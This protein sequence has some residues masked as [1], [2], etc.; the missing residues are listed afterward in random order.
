MNNATLN[1][2]AVGDIILEGSLGEKAF[3][4]VAPVLRSG[5]V[6][7]GQGECPF[8]ARGEPFLEVQE[9]ANY[10][11]GCPPVHMRALA[12][13]G[14]N[15]ITPCSNH[16]YN[17]GAPGIED[18]IT[19]LK[20]LGIAYCG[21]GM[22]IDEA[23]RPAVIE[24]KGTKVGVL[25]YNCV[26]PKNSW[27]LPDRPGCAFV[28]V[29]THYEPVSTGPG[30]TPNIYSFPDPNSLKDMIK[31][32]QKLRPDCDVLVVSFHKGLLDGAHHRLAMYEQTISYAAIDAGADLVLGHHSHMLKGIEIYRGKA[33]FHNLGHF[34]PDVATP[35]DKLARLAKYIRNVSGI[36][37]Q[38]SGVPFPDSLVNDPIRRRTIIARCSI[39][40]GHISRVGYI[41]CLITDRQPRI[42]K[43]DEKGQEVFDHLDKIT[44]EAGLDTRYEWEGDEVIIYG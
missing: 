19:G 5:D 30:S 29:I 31:D 4:F 44:R 17:L 18:T 22:N 35:S 32:I 16:M 39:N 13:A 36:H 14:F 27:A 3:S 10:S 42:L 37:V 28:N 20:N 2:L 1:L 7:V 12:Y 43:H 21:A 33:I 25:A 34:V 38:S 23:R 9:D 41:P 11:P 6:V 26:G 24:R 15:V 8:T 40:Q